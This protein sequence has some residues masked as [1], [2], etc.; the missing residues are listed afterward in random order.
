MKAFASRLEAATQLLDRERPLT[1]R[2]LHRDLV[3]GSPLDLAHQLHHG[4]SDG[5]RLCAH[6]QFC[7]NPIGMV[8]TDRPP[9]TTMVWPLIATLSGEHRKAITSATSDGVA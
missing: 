3:A 7:P 4:L 1:G 6:I 9:S 5:R 2:L 8:A